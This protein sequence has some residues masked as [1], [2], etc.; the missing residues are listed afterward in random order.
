MILQRLDLIQTVALLYHGAQLFDL[1]PRHLQ[2]VVDPVQ[3]HLD[4]HGVLAVQQIAEGRYHPLLNQSGHLILVATYG[5]VAYGPGRFLL[6]LEV[7]LTQVVN[8]VRQ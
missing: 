1:R 6:R 2:H 4:H 3:D 8:D 5:E 7:S